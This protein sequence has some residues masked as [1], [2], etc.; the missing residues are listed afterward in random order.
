MLNASAAAFNFNRLSYDNYAWPGTPDPHRIN[1]LDRSRNDSQVFI[2]FVL[3]NAR[4]WLWLVALSPVTRDAARW[5]RGRIVGDGSGHGKGH[6]SVENCGRFVQ[7]PERSSWSPLSRSLDQPCNFRPLPICSTDICETWREHEILIKP[8][9]F[10]LY[11]YDFRT[12]F[13]SSYCKCYIYVHMCV[14][15]SYLSLCPCQI[16]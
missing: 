3:I 5:S 10:V 7:Q 14:F 16:L 4:N 13:L 12:Y 11:A 6:R 1:H 15:F 9:L 8:L 2:Y